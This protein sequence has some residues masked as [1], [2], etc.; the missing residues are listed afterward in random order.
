MRSLRWIATW[1]IAATL[2]TGCS[3]HDVPSAVTP[4]SSPESQDSS[5]G[6]SPRQLTVEQARD[7]LLT[8]ENLGEGYE[9][10]PDEDG[11]GE[12]PPLGC[13]EAISD[14]DKDVQ[15]VDAKAQF[16]F[17]PRTTAGVPDVTSGVLSF[18]TVDQAT[19]FMRRFA[20]TFASCQRVDKRAENGIAVDLSVTFED[21]V[22]DDNV[23][24]QANLYAEGSFRFQDQGLQFS[25]AMSVARAKN[26]IIAVLTTDLDSLAVVAPLTKEYLRLGV[27]RLRA[28]MAGEDPP[29][30]T[31]S[32]SPE[33][34]TAPPADV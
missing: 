33:P 18:G 2:L 7:A 34:H 21:R 10:A 15:G 32:V 13:L 23:D 8:A 9:D 5:L 6:S 26:N 28:V 1:V 19:S 27:D 29:N 22:A 11:T 17:M 31:S 25:I 3:D 16:A 12:S 4:S 20:S 30:D 24:E 14:F